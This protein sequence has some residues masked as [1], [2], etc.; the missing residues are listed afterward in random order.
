[1]SAPAVSQSQSGPLAAPRSSLAGAVRLLDY[2]A[3]VYRR[4][5][6][7]SAFTS[8]VSPLLYVVAMGVLLGGFVHADPAT[9]DGAPSYLAFVAPGLV[10]NQAMT[11]VFGEVTY[12]VMGMVK[13]NRT[14]FSMTATPLGVR[15]VVASHL[16]FVLFR[17]ATGSAVFL[18]VLAPFGVWHSAPGT[19]GAFLAL[20][21]LGMA[22]ATPIFGYS[23]GLR[24]ESGFAL[25]FRLGM[26]PLSLF[27]GTFFPIGNLPGW[28]HA[29]AKVTPLWQGVDLT[30][31]LVLGQLRWGWAGIHVAYLLLCAV[32]GWMWS[33][34]RLTAR[35]VD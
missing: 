10:A 3:L 6:K 5:W 4:T 30:R 16:A 19:I 13:W 33:V 1:M 27:S 15:D 31:M 29:V 17:V 28:L 32:L 26:I 22:F 9:L 34:R 24:D 23:A 18:A 25:I 14:Y 21:L 20:L 8:F 7:G 35:M 2:W 12:P 11:T